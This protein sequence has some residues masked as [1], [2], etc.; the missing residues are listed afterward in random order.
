MKHFFLLF[1]SIHFFSL[2]QAQG[3][4]QFNAVKIITLDDGTQTVPS[5]KVWK[6][7]F[8]SRDAIVTYIKRVSGTGSGT[9]G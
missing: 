8:A 1:L 5:G 2:L 4:L 3:N 6:I 9:T 7:N